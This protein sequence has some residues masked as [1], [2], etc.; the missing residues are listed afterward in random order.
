MVKY[1]TDVEEEIPDSNEPPQQEP[2][3]QEPPQQEPNQQEP[4]HHHTFFDETSDDPSG[5]VGCRGIITFAIGVS[6]IVV[7]GLYCIL[8]I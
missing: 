1:L 7:G 8:L 4:E 3:Q 6:S 2:P 5:Q